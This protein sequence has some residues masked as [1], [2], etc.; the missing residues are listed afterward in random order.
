MDRIFFVV[1]DLAELIHWFA[2]DVEDASEHTFAYGHHDCIAG[3]DHIHTAHQS[4]GRGHCYCAHKAFAEVLLDFEHEPFI[5]GADLEID[6]QGVIDCRHVAV[7]KMHID[8]GAYD[9]VYFTYIVH[10]NDEYGF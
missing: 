3:V 2:D 6:F 8:D 4:F 1:F 10:E 7:L 9:L 5:I